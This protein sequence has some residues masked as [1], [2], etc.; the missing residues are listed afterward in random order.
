MP[1]ASVV[2]A[3][4]VKPDSSSAFGSRLS[5]PAALSS[6][7]ASAGMSSSPNME[8]SISVLFSEIKPFSSVSLEG[9]AWLSGMSFAAASRLKLKS[10]RLGSS[11]FSFSKSGISI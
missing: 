8:R 2:S 1:N 6:E 4:S 10:S 11:K 5:S 7:K 3:F 9:S